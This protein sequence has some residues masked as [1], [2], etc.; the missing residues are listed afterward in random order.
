M[1]SVESL[2]SWH[3]F[4]H[5]GLNQNIWLDWCSEELLQVCV[6]FRR[7]RNARR[8]GKVLYVCV[9]VIT[10]VA[11]SPWAEGL[12]LGETVSV[13]LISVR[14][15][16]LDWYPCLYSVTNGNGLVIS[17]ESL[18]GIFPNQGA[19]ADFKPNSVHFPPF[20]KQENNTWGKCVIKSVLAT[21][22]CKVKYPI[23]SY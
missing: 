19:N 14:M 8:H 13:L 12:A 22:C 21:L 6:F 5:W 23:T 2:W 20:S 18:L 3:C 15:S 17:V 10:M 11:L 16:V 4:G 9:T 7:K 1:M